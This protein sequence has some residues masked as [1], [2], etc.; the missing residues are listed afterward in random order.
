MMSEATLPSMYS[1]WSNPEVTVLHGS[2]GRLLN[3]PL[4]DLNIPCLI[5]LLTQITGLQ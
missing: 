3:L 1:G 4:R 5:D 2:A